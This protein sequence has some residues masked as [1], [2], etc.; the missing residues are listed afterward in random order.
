[1]SAQTISET[2]VAPIWSGWQSTVINGL[3][4]L[5]R[6]LSGSDRS[7][8]FLTER[9]GEVRSNAAVKIIPVEQVTLSQLSHWR[10]ATGLSH[11]HLIQLYDAGLCHFGG[12]QFLFVVMEYAEQTLSQV[13]AQRALTP[14]E[15]RE[16]LPPTL[17][18]L[19]FLHAK[20]LVQGQLK[21]SNILVVGDQL[22]L[23]S[24]S[25]RPA[26][27]PRAGIAEI[28][29]YDPPE[30]DHAAASPADDIW[31]LGM[32]LV[33]ALTQSLPWRD[34]QAATVRLPLSMP[35]EF[36]DTAQR[37]LSYNPADRPPATD[38]EARPGRAPNLPM[39]PIPHP[40]VLEASPPATPIPQA[41]RQHRLTPRLATI[42]SV[43]ILAVVWAG[44]QL[45]RTH[46]NSPQSAAVTGQLASLPPAVVPA[47]ALQNPTAHLPGPAAAVLTGN[48]VQLP[49]VPRKA[50]ATIHGHFRIAVLVVVDHSGTVIRALLKNTGPSPYFARLALEA[51][52]KSRFAPADRP[53]NREWQLRF[54]FTRSGV[55]GEASPG[56]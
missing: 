24:D 49:N 35:P 20:G 52:M 6:F 42:G 38:L 23:A 37:C 36:S 44:W 7:A 29:A 4:P 11:P 9:T 31:G 8:V 41:P 22:K 54:E 50:L 1:M 25:I 53:G 39:A 26:G 18:A 43:L 19:T 32:T 46:S 45:F 3:Y 34:E 27:A 5:Q 21:P 10:V 14:D 13:L 12:R 47:V 28:S 55:T 2:A 30:A 51:A 56:S 16:M 48:H 40:A 17:E 33:E 15:V